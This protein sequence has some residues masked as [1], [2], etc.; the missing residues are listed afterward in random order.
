MAQRQGSI[1][2]YFGPESFVLRKIR[3]VAEEAEQISGE[4]VSLSKVVKFL[5]GKSLIDPPKTLAEEYSRLN[6]KGGE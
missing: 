1:C 5:I 2:T 6:E 3:Q 4:S